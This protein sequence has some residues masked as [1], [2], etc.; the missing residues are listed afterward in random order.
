MATKKK[1]SKPKP[2]PL[3]LGSFNLQDLYDAGLCTMLLDKQ[4]DVRFDVYTALIGHEDT[5][6]RNLIAR[7]FENQHVLITRLIRLLEVVEDPSVAH[8]VAMKEK[9]DELT[10]KVENLRDD[11][12]SHER[13]NEHNY[14]SDC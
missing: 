14:R 6:I 2:D 5:K 3:V 12:N 4:N 11:F 13:D 10:H 1:L 8:A 7:L 9:I